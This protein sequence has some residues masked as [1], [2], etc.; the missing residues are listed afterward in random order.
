[1]KFSTH[2]DIFSSMPHRPTMRADAPP[3]FVLH[4]RHDSDPRGRSPCVR[5]ETAG[6][7]EV[8]RRPA[9]PR[10]PPSTSSAP[11]GA[12]HNAAGPLP[13]WVYCDPQPAGSVSYRSAI[14]IPRHA[15]LLAGSMASAIFVDVVGHLGC[16]Q[17]KIQIILVEKQVRHV[18]HRRPQGAIR[19]PAIYSAGSVGDRG[20]YWTT[21]ISQVRQSLR[22]LLARAGPAAADPAWLGQPYDLVREGAL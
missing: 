15:P 3:F 18:H 14:A 5:R 7:A 9:G 10:R 22:W 2:R 4:G 12:H 6:G 21:L 19:A 20:V 8:A 13:V 17:A 16:G 11:P 1:M